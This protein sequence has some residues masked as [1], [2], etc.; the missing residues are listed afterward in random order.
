MSAMPSVYSYWSRPPAELMADLGASPGGLTASQ[1]QA[2]ISKFGSNLIR[3]KA[4]AT[5]LGLFLN[6]FKSPIVLILLFATLLSAFLK[7][8]ADAVIILIIVLASALLSFYQEYNANS[9]AEQLRARV[10]LN[11]QVLRDG[12]VQSIPAEGVVPGDIVLLSAGSLI[13]ADGIVLE[14][15]DFF[16][17]Q[18]VLTGETFPVEKSPGQIASTAS[19]A[20]RTNTVFMGTSTR[21]GTARFLVVQTGTST[22][23]GQIARRLTLRPPETEFERGIRRL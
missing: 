11:A 16:V 14:T 22:A 18:A 5:P 12:K 19:L 4:S 1:A 9:A 10:T 8:W 6:Q 13:P 7:D 23:F 20:E 2:A 3:A 21:S 15:N 17:N